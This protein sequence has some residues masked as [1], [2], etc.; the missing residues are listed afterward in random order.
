VI[1]ANFQE[2]DATKSNVS[3]YPERQ[4]R[5]ELLLPFRRNPNLSGGS[6]LLLFFFPPRNNRPFTTTMAAY[7]AAVMFF[8]SRD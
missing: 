1:S 6:L 4:T 7:Y 5:S 3:F 2:D 8:S